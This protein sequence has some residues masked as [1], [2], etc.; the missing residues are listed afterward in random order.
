M[1][2][3]A[4]PAASAVQVGESEADPRAI[5]TPRPAGSTLNSAAQGV[6]KFYNLRLKAKPGNYTVNFAV[7]GLLRALGA[8]TLGVNVR[9]CLVG[10]ST[11]S[12]KDECNA[13]T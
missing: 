5:A 11:T 4:E 12:A 10:E 8:L 7:S 3:L 2:A 1:S 6:V 13:C 9:S